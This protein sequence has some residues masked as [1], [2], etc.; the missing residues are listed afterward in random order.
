[1]PF[2]RAIPESE[3]SSKPDSGAGGGFRS[4]VQAEKLMQIALVLP[5]AVVIGWLGG[6]WLGGRLHQHWIAIAGIIFGSVAG[7]FYLI[8]QAMAIEKNSRKEDTTQNGA[9]K[10][11]TDDPS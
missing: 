4:Y 11:N 1:M 2:H 5:S 8:Q 6:A 9:G 10:G 3:R 7:L